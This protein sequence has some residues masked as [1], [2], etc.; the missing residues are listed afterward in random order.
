VLTIRQEVE[1]A[2]EKPA[3]GGRMIARH[4]GQV[5]L[6]S[7]AIPGE[8]VVARIERTERRLAFASVVDVKEHSPD[9]RDG[10]AD[11]LCGGCVYSHIAYSRQLALKADIVRDA[12]GR[13]GRI[14]IDDPIA[15]AASPEHGYRMRARFHVE[16][17]RVGFYREGTHTLCD[18]AQTRQ[19]SDE[20]RDSVAAA[21]AHLVRGG[22]RV[23]GV[24]LTESIDGTERA[25]SITVDDVQR[26]AEDTLEELPAAS[27]LRG[28]A[29]QDARGAGLAAGDP[30]VSDTLAILSR[31]R[32]EAGVLRRH[33]ASF[34]QANRYLVPD[35][36]TAVMDAV[37]STGA[38][39]DL[40]AG[41]GLFTV[42]L[43]GF[44]ARE[45]T[46]VEGDRASGADL[47][48]NARAAVS[49][50]GRVRVVLDSVERYLGSARLLVDT[51]VVD[52]PRT[53][54]SAEAMSSL[55][56]A[57]APRL[58][59]VSCDPAT[60]ARDAR[61]LV[62]G[63]YTLESLRAFDLFPNTPHI[64]SLGV[65]AGARRMA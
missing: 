50:A 7:G 32:L 13:I 16:G 18:A 48:E 56:Q 55:L 43:A 59:Y 34:F 42:A 15:V 8:R 54:I 47:K 17:T 30:S 26:V 44:G 24:E 11:P 3:A 35:L 36:V 49:R 61:W 41:V 6:V 1:L 4:D 14:P 28:C 64:E 5:V 62:D 20:A 19:V 58:I 27:G 45:M 60:M 33:A 29:I 40:Y 37:P 12:F 21:V 57:A 10:I 38:V 65:F 25:L 46:A 31:S 52:P 23:D 53:G 39:L 51:I 22:A 63:G 9:R 2:I